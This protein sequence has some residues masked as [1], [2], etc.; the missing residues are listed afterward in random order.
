ML[1]FFGN[2]LTR[3]EVTSISSTQWKTALAKAGIAP[4]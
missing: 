2:T 1:D 3:K 4:R